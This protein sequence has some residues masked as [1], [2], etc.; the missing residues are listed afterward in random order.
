MLAL[1]LSAPSAQVARS[2]GASNTLK[3]Q[4]MYVVQQNAPIQAPASP[5]VSTILA[6]DS[7]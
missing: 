2:L 5:K 4:H 1:R 6:P 3:D 7:C